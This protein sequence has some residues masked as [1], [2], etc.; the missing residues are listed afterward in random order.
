MAGTNAVAAKKAIIALL[1]A[2]PKLAGVQV[3]Y[4]WPTRDAEREVISGGK[5]EFTQQREGYGSAREENLTLDLFIVVRTPGGTVEDAE[6]RAVELGSI[7]E[8]VVRAN[9]HLAGVKVAG[10]A[11]GDS[12]SGVDD[13][14]A[15]CELAYHIA[16]VSTLR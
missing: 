9:P 5:F 3:A 4:S 12:N 2:A 1:R 14:S 7:V 16:C 13:D 8:D 10:V 6:T 15:V 11:G